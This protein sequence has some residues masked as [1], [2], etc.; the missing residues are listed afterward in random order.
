MEPTF[1][2]WQCV[3]NPSYCIAIDRK[4]FLRVNEKDELLVLSIAEH[5]SSS[6]VIPD[7]GPATPGNIAFH[8]SLHDGILQFKRHYLLRTSGDAKKNEI[9]FKKISS[10]PASLKIEPLATSAPTKLSKRAIGEIR[11][12]LRERNQRDQQSRRE[13]TF[14]KEA[15]QA[16]TDDYQWLK[17][18]VMQHGWIDAHRFGEK[19]VRD[20]FLIAQHCLD[21]RLRL[22]AQKGIERDIKIGK[23]L[24]GIFPWIYDRNSLYLYGYQRFG[25][26]KR[27]TASG[28]V[29]LLPME[30]DTKAKR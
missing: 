25:T 17:D 2:Y 10:K 30:S 6:I 3:D 29:E 19:A 28:R 9:Q 13:G 24:L 27:S 12:S 18:T 22:T 20:A 1:G 15:V 8:Y 7:L 16:Q 5:T 26:H 11:K 23:N 14:G 4:R 21:M